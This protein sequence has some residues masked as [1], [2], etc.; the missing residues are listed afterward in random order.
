MCLSQREYSP[1]KSILKSTTS[2]GAKVNFN[3]K[4]DKYYAKGE[5]KRKPVENEGAQK[6]EKNS[7]KEAPLNIFLQE[8]S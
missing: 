8:L 6:Q 7:I 1:I 3:E 2:S 4:V 5:N